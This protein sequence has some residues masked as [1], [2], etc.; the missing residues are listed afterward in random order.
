LAQIACLQLGDAVDGGVFRLARIDRGHGGLLDVVGR[1]EIGLPRAQAD[2]VLALRLEFGREVRDG[3][4]G[5]GLHA[6]I[7]PAG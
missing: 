4:G 2:H 3:D 1:V 6:E 5:G 7:L